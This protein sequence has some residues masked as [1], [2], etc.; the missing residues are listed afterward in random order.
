MFLFFM[1]DR[2]DLFGLNVCSGNSDVVTEHKEG[3][4]TPV[5][6][7]SGLILLCEIEL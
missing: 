1:P 2:T 5:Q 6:L 7:Y 3:V 4:R